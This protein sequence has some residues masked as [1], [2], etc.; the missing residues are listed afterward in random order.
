MVEP[1]SREADFISL[2]K[3]LGQVFL[4]AAELGCDQ[5]RDYCLKA[6]WKRFGESERRGVGGVGGVGWV[7]GWGG[8]VCLWVKRALLRNDLVREA[9]NEEMT[10]GHNPWLHLG[11]MNIQLPP[12]LRFTR[13]TGWSFCHL[14]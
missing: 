5:W 11:W 6:G 4:A 2:E 7:G 13:G 9:G 3:A 14:L 8:W 10:M 12:I 1:F